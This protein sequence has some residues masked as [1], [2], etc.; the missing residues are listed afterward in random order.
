M[1]SG[2]LIDSE[3]FGDKREAQEL[4]MDNPMGPVELFNQWMYFKNYEIIDC[5]NFQ[6]S[7]LIN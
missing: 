6:S 5:K 4:F 7:E 3:H 1:I 2:L